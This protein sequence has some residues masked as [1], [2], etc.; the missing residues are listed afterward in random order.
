MRTKWKLPGTGLGVLL[1]LLAF[2]TGPAGAVYV[3]DG[4]VQN[5]TTDVGTGITTN[6]DITDYGV[7]VTGI[8]ADGTI[9]F[10]ATKTSRP[11]CLTVKF[12]NDA[13]LTSEALC[14]GDSDLNG[15]SHF[16]TST[17]VANDGTFISLNGLDRTA[18]MCTQAALKAGKTSGTMTSKCTGAWT[19]RGPAGDGAPG[20]CYTGVLMP[21]YNSS[22]TCP[23]STVGYSWSAG[24]GGSVCVDSAK[25]DAATCNTSP[26]GYPDLYWN[27][28]LGSCV[29]KSKAKADCTGSL[30]WTAW[31]RC[32]N[33]YGITGYPSTAIV[34]KKKTA[35][36]AVPNQ[37][38]QL[39]LSAMTQGQCLLAGG[40]WSTGVTKSSD[41]TEQTEPPFPADST[42]AAVTGSRAGC[43]EC[44]NNTS[45]Y[46]GYA[47][48][49]KTSYLETGHKNMLRKVTPGLSWAG[50]DGQAYT[51]DG[52]NPIDFV[53]GSITVNGNEQ[54]LYYVYGDWMAPLPSVVYGTNGY[55][56]APGA[57]N[58]Y[59]CAACHSTGWSNST[60]GVCYPDSTKT[61]S[62]TC[63]TPNTWVP[64]T[65]VQGISGAEPQA[66]FPGITGITGKWDRD[67]IICSRCHASVF[68]TTGTNV[69]GASF[70]GPTGTSTHN[71][72]AKNTT[73][74]ANT[75]I[76]FG[77]HQSPATT[78]VAATINSVTYPANAKILDPTMI[79]TGAGHGSNWGRE[80]NGH[81]LGNEFLNS[82]HARFNGSIV[83][84]SVGKY[85]LA[86][87]LPANYS[88]AF[89][90]YVCRSS[91]TAG[92]SSVLATVIKSG[93]IEP[94]KTLEDCNIANGKPA[95]D[96]TSYGYWQ[97]ES[98]GNCTTCHD[99][100]QSLFDPTATE[101]IRRECTTCHDNTTAPATTPQVDLAVINHLKTK[102][103][104]L[105]NMAT[106]PNESCE[107]CHMP[108][109]TAEG[110]PMHLWRINTDAAYDTFPSQNEFYGTGGATKDRRAK[111]APESY[112]VGATPATYANAV[113]VDIDLTCGQCHGGGANSTDN[114]VKI[115]PGVVV[116]YYTKAEL[117]AVA[118]GMH[119]A[120]G[121][122]YLVNFTASATGLTA[123]VA[124]SVDCGGTCPSLTYDWN[125]GDGLAHGTDASMSHTYATGGS[126]TI[127][128]TV[129][130]TSNGKTVGSY[131]RSLNLVAVDAP[132]VVAGT[133]T[134]NA[135]NWTMA[136]VDSSTD[137]G[138]PVQVVVDWGD[139]TNKTI[140]TEGASASHLYAR[141]GTFTVTQR[142]TD[143]KL[144]TAT[145]TCATAVPAYFTISG[146]VTS[147][148]AAL[149]GAKIQI[150]LGS[151][152][153]KT[154]T[155][156][157]VPASLG[158]FT[159]G[160]TLK[161]GT[162]T[163][164]ISKA[165]YIFP[166]T[167]VTVGPNAN[168]E[169]SAQS[170]FMA[171]PAYK[172]RATA[173]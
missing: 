48:R 104:P 109:P 101:P 133:C 111:T 36:T 15:G 90:G 20:F 132:P 169:I 151:T 89:K 170:A 37:T 59:T 18:T 124:A 78:Y 30:V 8:Q 73:S 66:S 17:C 26:A 93:V 60:A 65:G 139:G 148:H 83:P 145:R 12:S 45:Q 19:Y 21:H 2:A 162:Y 108:K 146:T 88:S 14:L 34:N 126:K 96:T 147:G 84:N 102:G 115:I 81:V 155:S 103:T 167:T 129:S 157:T 31:D 156:S 55:L 161:P 23:T 122:S 99:V 114:P 113:W 135:N 16:W 69:N 74:E 28:I 136:F 173:R 163:L 116:P 110:F 42:V 53:H 134:F 67:G 120:A 119:D 152:L 150:K 166:A 86:T 43:L 98:T 82:P 70:A 91:T 24:D 154:L 47:E 57:T 49:W 25:T 131:T 27:E 58:G 168:Q 1:A 10:D 76:C 71:T 107:I 39:D 56:S 29:N 117:A 105:E 40:S 62:A 44:H 35:F 153:V 13:A 32:T 160:A 79:P 137:D 87:N 64:S 95:G 158:T 61:T 7:C 52:N 75:N 51:T 22:A 63:L 128:L 159:T 6:W 143:S 123:N 164:M 11:G 68:A 172:T 80:F 5:G 50:A 144:H 41:V 9:V 46:N 130:L 4:S 165:G 38:T 54:N 125:W 118:A 127:A 140:T 92:G 171:L 85:D 138:A 149:G 72:T 112:M 106:E 77:C 3:G 142:A 100:H 121:V 94:I 97:A 141:T 33:S